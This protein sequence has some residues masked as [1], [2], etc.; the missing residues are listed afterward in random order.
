MS[1]GN[2]MGLS[3][4]IRSQVRHAPQ[5]HT[6]LSIRE[7]GDGLNVSTCREELAAAQRR[8][9]EQQQALDALVDS[10][11]EAR[12]SFEARRAGLEQHVTE[13]SDAEA[14]CKSRAELM[15]ARADEIARARSREG[16]AEQRAA[17]LDAK[18]AKWR[19]EQL[20]RVGGSHY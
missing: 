2:E 17:A 14:V 6:Q 7:V 15:A 19:A 13:T 16:S 9:A 12:R 10:I 11:S 20:E 1:I 3:M 8:Q 4:P 5:L 18:A